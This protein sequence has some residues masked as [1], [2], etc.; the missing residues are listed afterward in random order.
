MKP[1]ENLDD[2]TLSEMAGI[3]IDRDNK[4]LTLMQKAIKHKKA[5]QE[6]H[7]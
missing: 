6:A 5:S 2:K 1:H 3:N 7:H 4:C